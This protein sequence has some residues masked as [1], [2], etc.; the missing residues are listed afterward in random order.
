[1]VYY[2]GGSL[3]VSASS[4]DWGSGKSYRECTNAG[5]TDYGPKTGQKWIGN[6]YANLYHCTAP[7]TT[8]TVATTTTRKPD[9][10]SGTPYRECREKGWTNYGTKTGQKWIG[11]FYANLYHC[12]APT[13]TTTVATT[14]T[15]KPDWGS[16]TP[17]RECREKGWTNYGTKTGQKWIGGA[18]KDL[19]QC[20]APT[21]TTTTAAPPTTTTT[22]APPTTT[23]TVPTTTTTM[24]QSLAPPGL[25][26]PAQLAYS[27]TS[28]VLLVVTHQ[29]EFTELE[30]YH[31]CSTIG[32]QDPLVAEIQRQS[33][34]SYLPLGSQ[35][36]T[37]SHTW[38]VVTGSGP[39]QCHGGPVS[40]RV[41]VRTAGGEWSPWQT[42]EGE[43]EDPPASL[44]PT[45]SLG[46]PSTA[47]IAYNAATAVRALVSS[48]QM[49]TQWEYKY[50]CYDADGDRYTSATETT[51]PFTETTWPFSRIPSLRGTAHWIITTGG[52]DSECFSR[53]R[54]AQVLLYVRVRSS[55][56]DWSDWA[57][58][59]VAINL[60]PAAPSLSDLSHGATLLI[61]YDETVEVTADVDTPRTMTYT[62]LE[63]YVSCVDRDGNRF[64]SA[65]MTRQLGT[66]VRTTHTWSLTTGES[67]NQ[68]H[69]AN[70]V[71]LFVRA[72]LEDG[73]S[74]WASATV[75]V[76]DPVCLIK[77]PSDTKFTKGYRWLQDC[78]AKHR[79]TSNTVRTKRFGL[80]FD[81]SAIYYPVAVQV[82]SQM[83]FVVTVVKDGSNTVVASAIATQ[84]LP[85]S[86]F[87]AT[88]VKAFLS[89]VS[90]YTIE[91]SMA[92]AE[93]PG[94][95]NLTVER[96]AIGPPTDLVANGDS[97]G[98]T[99]SRA[100][101]A[102]DSESNATGYKVQYETACV[103]PQ[104]CRGDRWLPK[105]AQTV[106]T[107]RVLL[108]NL[109][110]KTLYRV[111]VE[112][113]LDAY[114]SDPSYVYVYPTDAALPLGLSVASLEFDGYW[115]NGTY[116]YHFC[117]DTVPNNTIE[118]ESEIKKGIASWQ[119]A[120]NPL[121]T[122]R[123]I[124]VDCD[125]D[126]DQDVDEDDQAISNRVRLDTGIRLNML[127]KTK[128]V[129]GCA[130][131]KSISAE[132]QDSELVFSNAIDGMNASGECRT[133]YQ[134]AVHEAGH[135]FG[136]NGNH[137]SLKDSIMND[138]SFSRICD[139]QPY[140][141]VAMKALYQSRITASKGG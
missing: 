140:D 75:P 127:C 81:G 49:F 39:D 34:A 106:T 99:N 30:F 107:N 50:V 108:P 116:S 115:S 16:G 21:T 88:V 12:T 55:G 126:D 33:V 129:I 23:T 25:S 66:T 11:N 78:T 80:S 92:A 51:W 79:T 42:V 4:H 6:F 62:Q 3:L 65:R 59:G 61:P 46:N 111:K 137:P 136:F 2:V 44:H 58:K 69:H 98:Q 83:A 74:Q 104:V 76:A 53:P 82:T 70:S 120:A 117:Q 133:L 119:E 71:G 5:L 122:V 95:F 60:A 64:K 102:W 7:T 93:T 87:T 132:R 112:S 57:T 73:W 131:S 29:E 26:N 36:W 52:D 22:A 32:S 118:W 135:A 125:T 9:W 121:L 105:L 41:R 97:R 90:T 72:L 134:T 24:P 18:Y 77:L 141:I 101:I 31:E 38:E 56:T 37:V 91:V 100:D 128:H 47:N 17:Y 45:P 68:C 96:L 130:V 28:D 109:A 27:G 15:R 138:R 114:V 139:P 19:Y 40:F 86:P 103:P 1:M 67:T 54:A 94:E 63:H 10:G 8:T 85:G 13:T 123:H 14:T 43:I 113:F 48:S 35:D 89:V 110:L 84:T 20:T 124:A